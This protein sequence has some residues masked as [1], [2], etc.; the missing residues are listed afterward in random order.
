MRMDTHDLT[1]VP[2][3]CPSA[4]NVLAN[5]TT[6]G[7][8]GVAAYAT[9]DTTNIFLPCSVDVFLSLPVTVH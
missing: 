2:L 9:N 6:E 1:A 8:D 5:V 4:M 7:F 3:F